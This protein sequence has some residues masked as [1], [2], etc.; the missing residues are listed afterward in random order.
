MPL[1][2]KNKFSFFVAIA[3]IKTCTWIKLHIVA[4]AAIKT[5]TW[6]KLHIICINI[7]IALDRKKS[8]L[9]FTSLSLVLL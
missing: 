3:A 1:A 9:T 8:H 4:I 2:L 6:I 7:F 5:C